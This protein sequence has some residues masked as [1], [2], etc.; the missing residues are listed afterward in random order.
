[1]RGLPRGGAG[2]TSFGSTTRGSACS[3]PRSPASTGPALR[4]MC[5]STRRRRS[6]GGNLALEKDDDDDR[7]RKVVQQP[8]GLRLHSAGGRVEGCVCAHLGRRA[9]RHGEPARGPEAQLRAGARATGENLR[10]Q[11]ETGLNRT[12]S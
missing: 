6:G 11:F 7:N 2:L 4:T 3:S 12:K 9:L 8:E 10:G 5:N 1:P